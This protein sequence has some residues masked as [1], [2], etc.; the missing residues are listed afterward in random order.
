L[1][2]FDYSENYI[3]EDD[4]VK[5]SPLKIE[6]VEGLLEISNEWNVWTYFLEKGNGQENLT[7]YVLST[8][9]NRKLKKEFPFVI[10]DKV[11][12]EYAGTTR[13]YDYLTDLK[14]IKL[15][16]TWIGEKFRGTGLNKHCKYLLFEF[17]FE[18]LEVERIGFGAH[19]EN[20]RSIAAMKKIG[21]KEEGV[22]RNFIPSLDG[23]GRAHIILLSITKDEWF[24]TIKNEL[25][26]KLTKA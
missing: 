24:N 9:N 1:F 3:L 7:N 4:F 13:L 10:F 11:K 17:A 12:N 14:S 19:I 26:Q 5:L 15:G 22:L 18:K 25:Q 8:L 20:K 6:H 23:K 2:E 16:H 21:C